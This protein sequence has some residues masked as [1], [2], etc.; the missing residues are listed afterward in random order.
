MRKGETHCIAKYS[1]A[2]ENICL[3]SLLPGAALG[4]LF[5]IGQLPGSGGY[6]IW[7]KLSELSALNF[8]FTLSGDYK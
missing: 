6:V 3:T 5:S 1:L 7:R 4:L 8:V 2:N